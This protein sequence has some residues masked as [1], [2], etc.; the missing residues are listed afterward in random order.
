MKNAQTN[1]GETPLMYAVIGKN[2]GIFRFLLEHGANPKIINTDGWNTLHYSCYFGDLQG[3]KMLVEGDF[4]MNV[5]ETDK[6][7]DTPLRPAKDEGHNDIVSFLES[8]G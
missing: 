1:N 5:N 7:G 6:F 8:K 2:F 4:G 3:V